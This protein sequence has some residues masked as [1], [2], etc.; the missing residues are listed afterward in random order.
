MI[1]DSMHS[2]LI[3]YLTLVFIVAFFQYHSSKM[4]RGAGVK[5]TGSG[6]QFL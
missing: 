3:S 1:L 5:N 2:F 6:D 4:Q